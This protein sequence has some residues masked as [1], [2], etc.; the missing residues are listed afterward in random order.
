MNHTLVRRCGFLSLSVSVVPGLH[1]RIK[2]T[3]GDDVQSPLVLLFVD[4]AN[5]FLC[6]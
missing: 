5:V 4:S 1:H 6:L 2:P 3:D